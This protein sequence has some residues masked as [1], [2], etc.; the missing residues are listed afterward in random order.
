MVLRTQAK[1]Q[2]CMTKKQRCYC[3]YNAQA[4][5]LLSALVESNFFLSTVSVMQ[6]CPVQKARRVKTKNIEKAQHQGG[7]PR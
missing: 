4:T 1:D 7:R 6:R 5:T 2:K 3:L